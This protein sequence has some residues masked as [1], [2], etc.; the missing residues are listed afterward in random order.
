MFFYENNGKFIDIYKLEP[1]LEDILEYK[2]SEMNKIPEG[3]K[4]WSAFTNGDVILENNGDII[5]I[6]ELNKYINDVNGL[7]Y[8]G[9]RTASNDDEIKYLDLYFHN[10]NSHGFCVVK[11]DSS[12][13]YII[14]L[15]K[16]YD[17]FDYS[18]REY[19]MDGIISVPRSLYLLEAFINNRVDL[20]KSDELDIILKLFDIQCIGKIDLSILENICQYRLFNDSYE[21]II[22]TIEESKDVINKVKKLAR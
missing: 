17:V 12:S 14:L 7:D 4:V 15:K 22:N 13:D 18:N 5:D 20:I 1:K 3:E 19:I 16:Y 11:N 8:H 6:S 2:K 21:S 9:L 10:I